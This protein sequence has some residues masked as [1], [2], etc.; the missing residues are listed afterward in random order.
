ME[1]AALIAHGVFGFMH[2]A[3]IQKSDGCNIQYDE[4]G[5][6]PTQTK[7]SHNMVTSRAFAVTSHEVRTGLGMEMRLNIK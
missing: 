5:T 4:D 3:S 6:F 2:E 1:A 7:T